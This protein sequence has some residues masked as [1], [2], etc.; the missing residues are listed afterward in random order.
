MNENITEHI[1][2][3]QFQ[4]K[5]NMGYIHLLRKLR[6]IYEANIIIFTF[7]EINIIKRISQNLFPTNSSVSRS[8]F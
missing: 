7:R 6:I 8:F 2:L 1:N 3:E 5:T 4:I